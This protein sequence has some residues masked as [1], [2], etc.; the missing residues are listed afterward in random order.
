MNK[1]A[2]RKCIL[3]LLVGVSVCLM[4]INKSEAASSKYYIK[5]NKKTNVATVY[6]SKDNKP[7]KAFLV[8]CGK[9]TP[10]GTF[11]TKAKYRWRPLYGNCYGQYATRITGSILFHSVWYYKNKDKGT[12]AV[13]E[14]NKLGKLASHGCVRL[15]VESSK[16]IYDNCKLKTKVVVFNGRSKDDPLGKPK[17]KK[18][19]SGKNKDWDPTDPD[20]KNPYNKVSYGGIA[21][22]NN[23]ININ[24]NI[25]I[26]QGVSAKTKSGRKLTSKI[27]V[28]VLEPGAKDYIDANVNTFKLTKAGTYKIKY[29]VKDSKTGITKNKTINCICKDPNPPV[30]N[31]V[32]YN[33]NVEYKSSKDL[34]LNV[35]ATNASKAN[36]TPSMEI[37]IKRPSQTVFNKY[38]NNILVFEELGEYV[39]RYKVN[40]PDNNKYV[41]KEVRFNCLDTKPPVITGCN[42]VT[43]GQNREFDLKYGICAKTISNIDLT[44]N[45]LIEVISPTGKQVV[46][47]GGI[48]VPEELGIYSAKYTVTSSYG[49]KTEVIRK[50]NVEEIIE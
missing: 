30:I 27:K 12:L 47:N 2:I 32:A 39:I 3:F 33:Q 13:K 49:T 19:T 7:Y 36:L 14:Y 41:K 18:I 11:Y 31:G 40:N 4:L 21:A 38:T 22:S 5:V 42:E 1:S 46:L 9:A 45:I 20:K 50:V 43:I 29:T 25:N 23:V 34:K 28:K 35:V 24:N 17:L 16:W 15:N 10:T 26:L 6:K 48:F 37:T 44:A 8:S